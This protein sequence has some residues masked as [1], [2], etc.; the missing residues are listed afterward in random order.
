MQSFFSLALSSLVHLCY[1]LCDVLLDGPTFW[2]MTASLV[3][4]NV[5]LQDLTPNPVIAV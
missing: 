1:A 3:L 5:R 4:R 2:R